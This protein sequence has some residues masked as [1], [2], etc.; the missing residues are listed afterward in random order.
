MSLSIVGIA[1]NS[2]FETRV[3][4]S[5]NSTHLSPYSFIKTTPLSQ[6]KTNQLKALELQ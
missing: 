3:R 6:V 1:G 4:D 5:E 2:L